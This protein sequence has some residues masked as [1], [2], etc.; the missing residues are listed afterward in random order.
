MN[1]YEQFQQMIDEYN[2]GAKNADEFFVQLVSFARN[3]N[4]EEQRGVSEQLSEEELAIFD[5]LTR[6]EMKLSRKEK[7][8]IKKVAQELLDTLKAE[9]L[10]LDWRKK[11]Q[12]R[13]AVQLTLEKVLEVLPPVYSQ[14]QY[15]KKCDL[16]YQHIYENYYGEGKSV[17]GRLTGS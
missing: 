13:A 9:R 16:V 7:E 5:I 11:Q 6:P 8:Q 4:E 15:L 2:K 17:Y 3:L 1:F 10:V 14:D 12:T